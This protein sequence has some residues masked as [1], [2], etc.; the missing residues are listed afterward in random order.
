MLSVVG[1]SYSINSSWVSAV[2]G[3]EI[4]SDLVAQGL[5]EAAI[6]TASNVIHMNNIE[7]EYA[8]LNIL[9][10]ERKCLPF[11]TNGIR[12]FIYFNIIRIYF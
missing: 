8:G 5:C 6:V 11:D 3:L 12:N 4:A 9:A 10:T 1:P 7:I 2:K